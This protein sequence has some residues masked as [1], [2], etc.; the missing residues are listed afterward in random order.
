MAG[1]ISVEIS[2]GEG[3]E[4]ERV[5]DAWI[6]SLPADQRPGHFIVQGLP[7]ADGWQQYILNGDARFR[8]HLE[9]SGLTFKNFEV[10]T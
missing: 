6:K 7:G 5:Y 8:T 1:D 3:H 10:R 2:L 9:K 4:L